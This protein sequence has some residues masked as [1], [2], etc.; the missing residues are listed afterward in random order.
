[1]NNRLVKIL[2][3]VAI[4]FLLTVSLTSVAL[5]QQGDGNQQGK[6]DRQ[7]ER[8][9]NMERAAN[10][11]WFGQF[12]MENG[13]VE[14]RFVKFEY[15][16]TDGNIS[17]FQVYTGDSFITIFDEVTVEN[18]VHDG[19]NISGAVFSMNG[20]HVKIM[21]HNNPRAIIQ[22]VNPYDNTP[23][24]INYTVNENIEVNEGI[25]II[26]EG[27]HRSA[28]AYQLI[29][30]SFNGVIN[31]PLNTTLNDNVITVDGEGWNETS[32]SMFMSKPSFTDVPKAHQNKVQN[33][34][35]NGSVGAEM[36]IV[37]KGEGHVS[38]QVHYRQ[39][40][41]MKVM[42]MEEKKLKVRVQSEEPNG[43]CV[44]LRVEKQSLNLEQ[45]K[46]QLKLD[47]EKVEK[48]SFEKVLQGGEQAKYSVQEQE[49]GM[50]EIAV[51]VPHF[52]EH[53]ITVEGESNVPGYTL[54]L[55]LTAVG[56]V[57][58]VWAIKKRRN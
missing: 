2:S 14:G 3:V 15:N 51:N 54:P 47:G 9:Q 44:M 28:F 57:A 56:S 41:E 6:G 21:I 50:L 52:S 37:G 20:T 35:M 4:A 27:D 5:A 31:T 39:N 22:I 16:D 49:D 29:G 45:N 25:D 32:H 1:M 33:S 17:N 11:N 26:G 7:Q 34:V 48:T 55:L 42:N 19:T 46:I 13:T 8:T 40:L 43:T 58:V 24:K 53:E 30:E 18:F 38:H 36:E 10:K 23:L 12:T